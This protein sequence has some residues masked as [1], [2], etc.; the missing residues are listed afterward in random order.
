MRSGRGGIAAPHRNPLGQRARLHVFLEQ[1]EP[2]RP[3]IVAIVAEFG[4][5]DP[6]AAGR[7]AASTLEHTQPLDG[8]LMDQ[9]D[10]RLGLQRERHAGLGALDL[11]EQVRLDF[12]NRRLRQVDPLGQLDIV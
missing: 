9:L 5:R 2:E 4:S 7:R 11:R 10:F 1:R 3:V 8:L 6:L 12:R